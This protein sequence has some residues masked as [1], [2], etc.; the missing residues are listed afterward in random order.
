MTHLDLDLKN[1]SVKQNALN[2]TKAAL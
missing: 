1:I 2:G